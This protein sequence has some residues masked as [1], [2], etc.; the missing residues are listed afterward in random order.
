MFAVYIRCNTVN[1]TNASDCLRPRSC[2]AQAAA[3]GDQPDVWRRPD[4]ARTR[5][6]HDDHDHRSPVL[7]LVQYL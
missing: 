3:V 6:L 5:K 1:L 4:N 2:W 7:E